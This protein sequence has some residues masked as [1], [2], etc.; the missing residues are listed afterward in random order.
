MGRGGHIK[1]A[2]AA[3]LSAPTAAAVSPLHLR[4]LYSF[5]W[6]AF[7][8]AYSVFDGCVFLQCMVAIFHFCNIIL[9]RAGRQAG[10]HT[11]R[12]AVSADLICK[13]S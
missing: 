4:L 11:H 2:A 6:E 3:P 5:L 12:Q 7:T 13:L 8:L 9:V 1:P 10:K